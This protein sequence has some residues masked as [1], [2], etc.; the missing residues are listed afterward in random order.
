MKKILSILLLALGAGVFIAGNN[1]S[2][3]AAYGEERISQIEE[4][5]QEN[6]RPIIGP[7]RR[8]ARNQANENVQEK[9]SEKSQAIG[10]S[11]AT[12]NLLQGAGIL[13]FVVG[14]GFLISS[15]SLKRRN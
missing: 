11:E 10:N 7:V 8:H 9:I 1:M 4:N 5:A 12:A 13:I 15:F 6:K 2:E 3:D 14:M